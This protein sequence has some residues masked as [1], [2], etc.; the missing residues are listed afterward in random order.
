MSAMA[1]GEGEGEQGWEEAAAGVAA[2]GAQVLM[3]L[4]SGG[5]RICHLIQPHRSRRLRDTRTLW[6]QN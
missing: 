2:K 5:E 3:R 4:S 1:P 6:T